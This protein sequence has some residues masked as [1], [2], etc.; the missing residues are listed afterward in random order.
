M[1]TSALLIL[2]LAAAGALVISLQSSD[3]HNWVPVYNGAKWA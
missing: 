2:A 3:A 1:R